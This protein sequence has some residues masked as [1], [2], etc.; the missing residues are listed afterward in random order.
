MPEWRETG[1]TRRKHADAR[2]EERST[3]EWVAVVKRIAA[4]DFASGRTG[5]WA[6]TPD[7]LVQP[8]SATKVLEGAYDNRAATVVDL[9]KPQPPGS[10]TVSRN[11]ED[12]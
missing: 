7:F 3:D 1:K 12:F 4:S 10:F 6:A 5:K 11:V 2:F 9:R 8:D